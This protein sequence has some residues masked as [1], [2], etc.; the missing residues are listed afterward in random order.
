M[1]KMPEP[2]VENGF[3]DS[4]AELMLVSYEKLTGRL[5]FP[6][7]N[8]LNLARQLYEASFVVLAH[9]SAPDPIF[10]YGNL[11]AQNIFNM[12]WGEL[13]SL[14]SRL[15]AEPS[16]QND[17]KSLLEQVNTKGYIDNY[18]GI[19]IS[20]TGQRF[21]IENATVWN[22]NDQQNQNIGQAAIFSDPILLI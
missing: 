20:K 3:H 13:T 12:T 14:P 17:R 1:N 18:S 5:L 6:N 10:I 16:N 4:I 11:K 22:L 9:N 15:S 7:V 19:R 21:R 2:S 8:N